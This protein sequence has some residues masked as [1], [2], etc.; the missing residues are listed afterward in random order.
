MTELKESY[1]RCREDLKSQYFI[2]TK[3]QEEVY[4]NNM[5]ELLNTYEQLRER[6]QKK[7]RRLSKSR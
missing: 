2:V 5:K 1:E 7:E 3:S 4:E 6:L